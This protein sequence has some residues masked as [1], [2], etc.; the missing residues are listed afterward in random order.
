MPVNLAVKCLKEIARCGFDK[1]YLYGIG[2]PLIYPDIIDIIE[3]AYNLGLTTIIST[4]GNYSLPNKKIVES[5]LSKII[6]SFDGFTQEIYETYRVGGNVE[7][8]KRNLVEIAELAKGRKPIVEAQFIAFKWN[9]M[10]MEAVEKFIKEIPDIIVNIKN[11]LHNSAKGH[12]AKKTLGKSPNRFAF[13]IQP[14]ILVNGE[15]VM[16]CRDHNGKYPLG[17]IINQSLEDILI[18]HPMRYDERF[19]LCVKQCPHLK[20]E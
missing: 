4:N 2:E 17:N 18:D 3:V 1:V 14:M 11:P 16:C 6:F 8:L 12:D 13:C 7:L 5:G 9:I 10:E 19:P 20:G 15:V